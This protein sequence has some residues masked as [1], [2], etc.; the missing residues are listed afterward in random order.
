ML[1]AIGNVKTVFYCFQPKEEINVQRLIVCVYVCVWC[2]CVCVLGVFSL[3]SIFR[4]YGGRYCDAQAV[5]VWNSF[6]SVL[7]L[8][9]SLSV[10]V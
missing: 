10:H 6:I 4:L 7:L 3:V 9:V 5:K 8:S 1:Y 2:V